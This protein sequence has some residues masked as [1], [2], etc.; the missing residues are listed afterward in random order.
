[1][2]DAQRKQTE[3]IRERRFQ[4]AT[5]AQQIAYDLC[6]DDKE[7]A[8]FL[9]DA[10]SNAIWD[11]QQRRPYRTPVYTPASAAYCGP[12]YKELGLSGNEK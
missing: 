8:R 10:I 12:V 6:L 7:A 3:L 4:A 1:M 2:N 11:A 9:S 5:E